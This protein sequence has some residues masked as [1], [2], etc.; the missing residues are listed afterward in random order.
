MRVCQRCVGRR[1]SKRRAD[2]AVAIYALCPESDLESS[3]SWK[4][5]IS[6]PTFCIIQKG[7]AGS[8][9]F[10][11]QHIPHQAMKEPALS[12]CQWV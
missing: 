4:A 2:G 6:R 11:I 12:Q 8:I 3:V 5:V 9:D 7:W 1:S 10:K